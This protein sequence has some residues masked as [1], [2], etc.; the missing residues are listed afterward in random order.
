LPFIW[1]ENTLFASKENEFE[2]IAAWMDFGD[3]D[4]RPPSPYFEI[5][6][7]SLTCYALRI[8]IYSAA[9]DGANIIIAAKTTSVAGPKLILILQDQN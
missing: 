3:V 9:R 4:D 6:L 5:G 8:S 7:P 2:L 1:S